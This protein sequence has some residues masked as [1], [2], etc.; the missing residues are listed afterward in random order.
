MTAARIIVVPGAGLDGAQCQRW[1]T[2]I[3]VDV[4]VCAG[5][6]AAVLGALAGV[7]PAGPTGTAPA[8]VGDAPGGVVIAPGVAG[9]DEE[10]LADAVAATPI[11]V[12]AVD[13]GNIR[14]AGVVP[15]STRLTAA[16]AC[17]IYG[18]GEDTARH[19][20]LYLARRHGER[21]D[22]LAYGR[23]RSQEGDLWLP[24]GE[25]PHPVAVLFHGG[26]WYHAWERDLMD[27][28]ARDLARRGIAAWNVEY[29]RVGAGGGWPATGE[30]AARATDHLVALAP[31]Y[32]LDLGRV[33]T[34]GHSAGAQL[35]LWVAARGRRGEVHPVLVVGLATI[36][37]LEEA[38]AA[39]TGGGSVAR[40]LQGGAGEAI[41]GTSSAAGVTGDV[42]LSLA[43]ASPRARV[44]I[45]VPQIL[46]HAVDDDIV[47]FSQTREYAAAA[48]R[49]GDE[50]AVV[51]LN[52]SGHFGVIDPAT[53]GWAEVAG[54]VEARL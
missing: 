20:L 24:Q 52:G 12:V 38:M 17:V 3:G 48:R 5:D 21:P 2:A 49:A 40:L 32:D 35:A 31:V 1:A 15:E 44:P 28:L 42:E 19:A 41:G 7:H 30:D 23:E 22:T 10:G 4:D 33:V 16:G 26:F 8:P 29:R 53:A 37:D 34:L 25:G 18:R 14:K 27:G 43:E 51:E 50:V 54:A 11:P 47:P 39:R 13:A 6:P 9:F 36:G 45:G 46:A